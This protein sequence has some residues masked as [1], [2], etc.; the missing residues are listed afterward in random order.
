M[1]CFTTRKFVNEFLYSAC[2]L[3]IL[4]SL[5]RFRQT[6]A[7][8]ADSPKALD[9]A[10]ALLIAAHL[11]RGTANQVGYG[12]LADALLVCHLV[13]GQIPV[14]HQLIDFLLV[15]CQQRA[16]EIIQHPLLHHLFYNLFPDRLL[17][18][19]S[20]RSADVRSALD[21]T[22][23][24]LRV[25][26]VFFLDTR[27]GPLNCRTPVRRCGKASGT[28]P[29]SFCEPGTLQSSSLTPAR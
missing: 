29:L 16:V 5:C 15:P 9:Q 20:R 22:T 25:C 28:R 7:A 17:H 11:R 3:R 26:Q 10:K 19:F 23:Q 1:N 21:H 8:A 6:V 27:A 2:R 18:A 4:Q 13:E 24:S 12:L 14:Y